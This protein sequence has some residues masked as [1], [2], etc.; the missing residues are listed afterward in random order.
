M[1][2]QL[3]EKLKSDYKTSNSIKNVKFPK[4]LIK[5]LTE[6]DK[7]VVGMESTKESICKA[8]L[9]LLRKAQ[10][11]N[12]HTIIGGPPG[13][14]KTKLAIIWAKI[15]Y[16][17]GFL[18]TQPIKQNM[19]EDFDNQT[20]GMISMIFMNCMIVYSYINKL[21]NYFAKRFILIGLVLL[22]V[23]Y[24]IF[25]TFIS[26]PSLNIDDEN[27]EDRD[28]IKV[29]SRED[30]VAP[31]VGQTEPKTKKLLMD[32]IGK[33]LFIDE[34]YS[35]I[36]S[37]SIGDVDFGNQVMDIINRFMS[38]YPNKIVIIFAGYTDKIKKTIMAS[39]PGLERRITYT[40]N[41]EKY[42]SKELW[43]ILLKHFE[44]C[45]YKLIDDEKEQSRIFKN[46]ISPNINIFENGQAGDMRKL[47][48]YSINSMISR[49][50]EDILEKNSIDFEKDDYIRYEDIENGIKEFNKNTLK[51]DTRIKRI[52]F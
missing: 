13:V 44:N 42:S 38:E 8:T 24:Y 34:A 14:G 17:I 41:C 12:A 45:Q 31:Y 46:L 47:R 3:I 5:A 52:V 1:L 23:L 33:V 10:D 6:L 32:N 28:I 7:D 22:G 29:V 40:F 27:V 35:L 49:M 51:D 39:Q 15:I 16:A 37:G 11:G 48:D 21:E 20:I 18:D 2:K 36:S 9:G 19:F 30:F 26:S 50:S 25:V 43:L 4:I